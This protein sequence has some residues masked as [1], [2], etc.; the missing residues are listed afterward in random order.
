MNQNKCMEFNR[1]FGL[2]LD[3]IEQ[4]ISDYNSPLNDSIFKLIK[5]KIHK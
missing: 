5:S 1:F 2:S 4:A 3:A